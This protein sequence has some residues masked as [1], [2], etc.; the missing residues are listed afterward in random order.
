MVRVRK[1]VRRRLF[2]WSVIM[3]CT[4]QGQDVVKVLSLRFAENVESRR[5]AAEQ[6]SEMTKSRLFE[7]ACGMDTT[8]RTKRRS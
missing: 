6:L 4:R 3:I 7:M 1:T 8:R 5:L 2:C